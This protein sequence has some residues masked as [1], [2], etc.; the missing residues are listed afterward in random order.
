MNDARERRSAEYR[1]RIHR[2]VD[3]ITAHL[4]E[5]LKLED[6]ARAAHF[7]PFHFHRVFRGLFGEP[8]H[9]FVRRLRLERAANRLL[10]PGQDPVTDIA[11]EVGFKSPAAFTRAFGD[12]FG[13]SPSE[14]RKS[15][16]GK[17]K[18]KD[19]EA[20]AMVDEALSTVLEEAKRRV[21]MMKLDVEVQE[22]PLLNIAYVRHIG[23][24]NQIGQAWETLCRWA[25]PRGLLGGPEV[26]MLGIYHDNPEV[27]APEKLR[28]DACVTVPPETEAD[29]PVNRS[30]V[31]GGLC[32]MARVEIRPDQFSETW[33]AMM[34]GWLPGSGYEPDD[35]PS[36]ELFHRTPEDHPEGKF[37]LTLCLPVRPL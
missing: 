10:E 31:P 24:Y 25:G 30:E 35:R 5:E 28:S 29:G 19:C 1:A 17:A 18:S 32:A 37:E 14:Y 4:G 21:A 6:I 13:L 2:A 22:R 11:Y 7:S 36:Y 9:G 20:A 15:K 3:Y 8:V 34:G 23:P 26:E 27:T 16:I 33:G 12:F